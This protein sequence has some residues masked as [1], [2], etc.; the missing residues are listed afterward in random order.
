MSVI[1]II[2][3]ILKLLLLFGLLSIVLKSVPLFREYLYNKKYLAEIE[4]DA[5]DDVNDMIDNIIT[6]NLTEYLY[7]NCWLGAEYIKQEEENEIFKELSKII[8]SRLSEAIVAKIS[9]IY[10]KDMI[11]EVLSDKIYIAVTSYVC[12]INNKKKK[13]MD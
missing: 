3:G 7:M 9:L 6:L 13:S 5:F 8:I 2:D 11:N 1:T 12:D 10:N 4:I